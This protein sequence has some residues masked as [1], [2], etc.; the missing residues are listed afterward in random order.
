MFQKPRYTICFKKNMV[1]K[2]PSRRAKPLIAHYMDEMTLNSKTA[3]A[4]ENP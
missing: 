2:I 4:K 1:Y 3:R